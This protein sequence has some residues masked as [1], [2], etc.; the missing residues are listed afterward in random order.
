MRSNDSSFLRL[1]RKVAGCFGLTILVLVAA[2][3]PGRRRL[4]SLPSQPSPT[5][6]VSTRI[7]RPPKPVLRGA[8]ASSGSIHYR[9]ADRIV[10]AIEVDR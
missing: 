1:S 5:F 7:V 10:D 8:R 3:R 2:S 4:R 9:V 6:G